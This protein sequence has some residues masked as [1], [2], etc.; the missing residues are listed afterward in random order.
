MIV[1]IPKSKVQGR[2]L[3]GKPYG[4]KYT[5]E[6]RFEGPFFVFKVDRFSFRSTSIRSGGHVTHSLP[7]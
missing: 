5:R 1:M 4:N 3:L 2:Q 6:W 7:I